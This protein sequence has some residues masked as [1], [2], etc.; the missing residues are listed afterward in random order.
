MNTA[1]PCHIAVYPDEQIG[2]IEYQEQKG[3]RVQLD[4]CRVCT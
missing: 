1:L 2:Q 3:G 4:F